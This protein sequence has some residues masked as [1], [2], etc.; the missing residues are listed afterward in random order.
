MDVYCYN[1]STNLVTLA[2][3][4]LSQKVLLLNAVNDINYR[5]ND[6]LTEFSLCHCN[7][8]LHRHSNFIII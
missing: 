7:I 2:M 6:L 8:I 4:Q 5:L 3:N 1:V